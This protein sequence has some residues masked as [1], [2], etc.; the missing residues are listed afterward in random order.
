M[1]KYFYLLVFVFFIYACNTTSTSNQQQNNS[2][3]SV[4]TELTD[5][6]FLGIVKSTPYLVINK[7]NLAQYTAIGAKGPN[8]ILEA[9][10]TALPNG[11]L[12]EDL[13]KKISDLDMGGLVQIYK[14]T[15][16]MSAQATIL[17]FGGN[18]G[19][20]ELVLV[21][22]YTR[23]H[24]VTCNGQ[25]KH[26]G[27][28]LRLFIHVKSLKGG[29]SAT[30]ANVAASV[31]LNR[32]TADYSLK[33]LGFGLNAD[34]VADGLSDQSDYNVDNFGKLE[35]TFTTVLRTLGDKNNDKQKISPVELPD[36]ASIKVDE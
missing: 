14:F 18:I 30:L 32:A 2:V 8:H 19:K 17:G 29:I 15:S 13:P 3:D 12:L 22:D 11:C 1:T 16:D 5:T 6:Q 26:Y 4:P 28:G 36:Q 20:K 34:I 10:T 33:T 27:I 25:T 9:L 23:Y 21:K 31:Q 24:D 35:A 7:S